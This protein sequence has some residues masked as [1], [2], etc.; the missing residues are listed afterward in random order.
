M[1]DRLVP[2]SADVLKIRELISTIELCHHKAEQRVSNIIAAIA[3]GE[4]IKGLGTRLPGQRHPA[5]I[6]WRNACA[7]LSAWIAGCPSTE[8]DLSIGTVPASHLLACLGERSPLKEWQVQRVIDKIRCTASMRQSPDDSAEQYVWLLLNEGE[9]EITTCRQCPE[10]YKEHQDFWLKT[11]RTIIYDTENGDK[12]ALS[13]GFV[14]DMLWPCHWGFVSNLEIVLEAINGR[15]IAQRPFAA[16]ARNISML[17]NRRR[18]KLVS[19]T[20]QLFCFGQDLDQ[21]VDADLLVMLGESTEVKKWLAASLDKTIR[22]QLGP[23]F[24]SEILSALA[25]PDWIRQFKQ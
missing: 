3:A 14:I 4:T 22:L 16:C 25:L 5:E 17:P 23:P 24:C 11:V 2:F 12:A 6:V 15:L 21:E 9:N 1:E 13:L 18:M 19:D 20:L 7:A 8:V 10:H